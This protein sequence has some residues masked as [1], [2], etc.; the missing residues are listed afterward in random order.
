MK[1]T[2][3]FILSLLLLVFVISLNK[4]LLLPI[5]LVLVMFFVY[6]RRPHL[7]I[8]AL[9]IVYVISFLLGKKR[10]GFQTSSSVDARENTNPS[11]AL[12]TTNPS[13][14][15]ATTNT[16]SSTNTQ[17]VTTPP[18][19]KNKVFTMSTQSYTQLISVFRALLEPKYMEKN[20]SYIEGIIYNYEVSSI[21][22]LSSKV[23]NTSANP[24]YNN[25]LEKVTCLN[26]G[27][28]N[29]LDC[30]NSNYKKLYAFSDLIMVFTLDLDK[31]FELINKNNIMSVCELSAKR[32]ILEDFDNQTSYGFELLGLKY[33]LNEKSFARK[34]YDI[35]KLLR[36]DTFLS[37][38]PEE[39]HLSLREKLYNYHDD[40][41]KV[42]KDLNSILVLFDFYNIFDNYILNLEDDDYRW[43]LGILK[44]V[45]LEL[46]C[47]ENVSFFVEYEV[48]N[49][50][51][52]GI[53]RST[54]A[55]TEILDRSDNPINPFSQT[56]RLNSRIDNSVLYQ[57]EDDVFGNSLEDFTKRYKAVS[58]QKKQD[59]KDIR[60]KL[61]RK[62]SLKYVQE[63]FSQKMIGILNDIVLLFSR[64]CDIDCSDS[65]NPMFSKFT[66]YVTEIIKIMMKDERMFYVGI[67]LIV[68]SMIFN[69]ISSSK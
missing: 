42:V 6:Q 1:N 21:F 36:L 40:N 39:S 28:V 64:K 50:I 68:L 52:E 14:A 51:I 48:K 59:N 27:T 63:N 34:Y 18:S 8:I 24:K 23:L 41:K 65:S 3:L 37:N 43:D 45:D 69:F 20:L 35:L 66:F 4:V 58:D 61:D 2:S 38:K 30:D 62:L 31:V 13:T 33:Y 25:F 54:R 53:Q 56:E 67:L 32:Q 11:T 17:Q 7:A 49:R 5:S 10:E 9:S 12:A 44:S 47:W 16:Q 22:D 29:Y 60:D 19:E 15:L 57:E 55:N 46:P 26:D